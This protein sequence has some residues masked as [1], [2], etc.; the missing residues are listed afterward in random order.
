MPSVLFDAQRFCGDRGCALELEQL[1]NRG[2][3]LRLLDIAQGAGLAAAVEFED[4]GL[5][6][7]PRGIAHRIATERQ[8]AAGFRG[9][10]DGFRTFGIGKAI[11][12]L[13]DKET[14]S[15]EGSAT[16]K[17][18]GGRILAPRIGLPVNPGPELFIILLG[19]ASKVVPAG[20]SLN[21][22]FATP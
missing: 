11:A 16:A 9:V 13:Q 19:E 20:G 10:V 15:E 3:K 12:A 17:S 21:Q 14:I 8:R 7:H 2:V 4:E 1:A 22:M 6:L 18:E 5:T